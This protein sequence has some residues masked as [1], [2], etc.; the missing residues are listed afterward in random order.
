[1]K[2]VVSCRATYNTPLF[3]PQTEPV[4]PP[5]PEP[6]GQST[7]SQQCREEEGKMG[8]S[9]EQTGTRKKKKLNTK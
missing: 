2:I 9:A 3:W 7:A 6:E 1:M 8:K 5:S 4:N